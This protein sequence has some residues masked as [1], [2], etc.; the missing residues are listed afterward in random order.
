M[1]PGSLQKLAGAIDARAGMEFEMIVPNAGSLDDGDQ[2]PDWDMDERIRG[3]SSIRDFFHDGDYNGRRDVDRLEQSLINDYYDS[4]WLSER[5]L[6]E[7]GAVAEE[8]IRDL[9]ERDYEDDLYEQAREDVMDNAPE[10]G[11]NSD[12][13]SAAVNERYQEL[14]DAKVNEILADMGREYDEAYEEW[15]QNEWQDMANDSDWQEEWLADQGIRTM[16]DIQSNYDISWPYYTSVEEEADIDAI[17]DDFSN[18]VGK[19]VNASRSYHGARREAGHYVVEPDGSLDPDDG[20][21]A[22]LEFVSPPL[23]INELLADLAKVK[24]WADA[25][26]CYTNKSTGLHI[27]VSVPN[28]SMEKLDYV[29]LALLLGD[30]YVLK[31]FGRSSNTYTKSALGIVKKRIAER[32]E[33]AKAMLDQMKTH[34]GAAASKAIHTGN[35]DKYTSINTK[36]G[37]IEFRSPGGDWLNANF[38]KIQNTLLRFTVAL[39]AAIDPEAYREE[40]LKKF[41]KLLDPQGGESRGTSG[42][43]SKETIKYFADYVAGNTPKAALRSFIKQAQLERKLKKGEMGGE[44]FWWR[45]SNP[46]HSD[47]SI[48]VV[49]T[50][51]EEAIAK[52]L[53]PSGYP[54]WKNT[55]ATV[56]ARPL[57]PY[58]EKPVQATL[59][60]PQPIGRSSGPMLGNRPSNPDGN[61]VISPESDRSVVAYRFRAA[62]IDDAQTVVRQWRQEHPDRVW[63]VQRDDNRTLGQ[64]AIPGSTLDLQ[65]QRA[66]A[67]TAG[68]QGNWGIWITGENRFSRAQG[69]SDNRVL[70]R[71]PSREAAEQWI[72]QTRATNP[73]LRPDIEVREIEPAAQQATGGIEYIIFKISDRSQLTGFRAANQAAAEREAESI[74]RDLGLDPDLYDI[75]PRHPA[76]EIPEVP[77]DIEIAPQRTPPRPIG[78]GRELIGWRVLLPTGE[79]VTQIHGI[80]NNQGDANRIAAEWLRQNGYGVSG[81][82]YEVVPLW[83]EA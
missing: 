72:E 80:G 7:W 5:K 58:E 69:Q 23:P 82:G 74:L 40:Y 2:E 13:L 37:Y 1:S 57:R 62:D 70:R 73:A 28:F 51:R 45:V 49:A 71:F 4:D 41:Y 16:Q 6:E 11:V 46:Q 63:I 79:E 44:P 53:E 55:I 15:E 19:P 38:D 61:Y 22:G 30:E 65:R 60:E 64:P 36:T 18:S 78:A 83:R 14:F 75:R 66:A 20:N 34:L 52:A 3:F 27:N 56:V 77:L 10:F 50:S 76:Q 8:H 81:E 21:D 59:G 33:D 48:E 67:Q 42:K 47:A 24:A 32:P 29:K 25:R 31:E 54:S 39:N 43:G 35:T 68:S 9:V 17:A 12:E 26:G